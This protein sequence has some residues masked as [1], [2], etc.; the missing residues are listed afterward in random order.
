MGPIRGLLE[1]IGM[2]GV[3]GASFTGGS[4]QPYELQSISSVAK[5]T[6]GSVWPLYCDTSQSP[7]IGYMSFFNLAYQ[8]C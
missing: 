8:E 1:S 2:F 6:L 5:A 4:Y 3:G 7:Y